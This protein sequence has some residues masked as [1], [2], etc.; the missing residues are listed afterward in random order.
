M[1]LTPRRTIALGLYVASAALV[2]NLV[3]LA[4]PAKAQFGAVVPYTVVLSETTTNTGGKRR[5]A[6]LQTW[7]VRSDGSAVVKLG[8]ADTGS[9]MMWLAGGVEITTDD[10]NRRKSSAR[11]TANSV[12]ASRLPS[13][14]CL[15][16]A[17]NSPP[18]ESVL[19]LESVAGYRA[20]KIS[21]GAHA[22]RWYALD[23]GCALVRQRI[24]FGIEGISE[25][26]LV[27]L[28]PGEPAQALFAV[29]VDYTEGPPSN[30]GG[31]PRVPSNCG[32]DCQERMRARNQR[33]DAYYENHRVY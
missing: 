2:I 14:Q 21:N 33:M 5:V 13:A 12:T 24:D 25:V 32:T 1:N 26:S 30:L 17:T 9:R 7:A 8:T 10:V 23:Y 6:S 20:V 22:T 28:I 4:I 29:P 18:G 11:V 27:N 15:G 3:R 19:S 31:A 16:Q